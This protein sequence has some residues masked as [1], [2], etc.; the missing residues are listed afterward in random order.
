MKNSAETL[1]TLQ[2][3][4]GDPALNAAFEAI[5]GK[6]WRSVVADLEE[7]LKYLEMVLNIVPDVAN[8]M[9]EARKNLSSSMSRVGLGVSGRSKMSQFIEMQSKIEAFTFVFGT[10]FGKQSIMGDM[11]NYLNMSTKFG[12]AELDAELKTIDLNDLGTL[13][14]FVNANAQLLID[15]G[16]ISKESYINDIASGT[17]QGAERENLTNDINDNLIKTLNGYMAFMDFQSYFYREVVGKV[18]GNIMSMGLTG[19]VKKLGD[20]GVNILKFITET[21]FGQLFNPEK[22]AELAASGASLGSIIQSTSDNLFTDLEAALYGTVEAY[23]DTVFDIFKMPESPNRLLD[24]IDDIKDSPIMNDIKNTVAKQIII[25]TQ[26]AM[27]AAVGSRTTSMR[28]GGYDK[29]L[30]QYD[31]IKQLMIANNLD[32]GII[33]EMTPVEDSLEEFIKDSAEAMLSVETKLQSELLANLNVTLSKLIMKHIPKS[34]TLLNKA[35][36]IPLLGGALQMGIDILSKFISNYMFDY[37]SNITQTTLLNT[38]LSLMKINTG[39]TGEKIFTNKEIVELSK[40]ILLDGLT[41]VFDMLIISPLKMLL[42][43]LTFE[44]IIKGI[45]LE[46]VFKNTIEFINS[47]SAL[48]TKIVSTSVV[49]WVKN[50]EMLKPLADILTKYEA[51]DEQTEASATKLIEEQWG[52]IKQWVSDVTGIKMWLINILDIGIFRSGII[53]VFADLLKSQSNNDWVGMAENEKKILAQLG[54]SEGFY[55]AQQLSK[56]DMDKFK[57]MVASTGGG[58]GVGADV[59]SNLVESYALVNKALNEV[60]YS[61]IFDMK[62]LDDKRIKDELRS[63]LKTHVGE[64]MWDQLGL[65]AIISTLDIQSAV[66]DISGEFLKTVTLETGKKFSGVDIIAGVKSGLLSVKMPEALPT[67]KEVFASQIQELANSLTE[68]DIET[69]TKMQEENWK[70]TA[71]FF[72]PQALKDMGIAVD[73]AFI[74]EKGGWAPGAQKAVL[75][76][77]TEGKLEEI[78]G[79]YSEYIDI[80]LDSITNMG[81]T[82]GSMAESVEIIAEQ[83]NM[84]AD[85]LVK[86]LKSV[87]VVTDSLLG[88]FSGVQTAIA[89]QKM[90][91]ETEGINSIIGG[92]GAAGGWFQVIAGILG[93][94]AGLYQIWVDSQKITEQ[95]LIAIR[96]NT[97]ALESLTN[98]LDSLKATVYGAPAGFIYGYTSPVIKEPVTVQSIPSGNLVFGENSVVINVNGNADYD[99]VSRAV[100]AGIIM[101]S[102]RAR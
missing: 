52:S 27:E 88:M 9:R 71:M 25:D 18:E 92:I 33:G 17:F 79:I 64:N 63:G 41:F 48:N 94:L 37:V 2:L 43:E 59:A 81:A 91:Q 86:G 38:S 77:L 72:K 56:N 69:L 65:E 34:V 85:V 61:Y 55:V 35:L 83:W 30:E 58:G 89:G 24:L 76:T 19:I 6:D 21:I 60:L 36:D 11:M 97:V 66:K 49:D 1:T 50:I 75:A 7:P 29:D 67:S 57:H 12:I 23:K 93:G 82:F 102:K 32:L 47:I 10:L 42:G 70:S 95:Q 16:M 62:G 13:M 99:D 51:L 31:H 96:Q 15:I 53:K 78:E 4:L 46:S 84:D 90:A 45:S 44:D 54:G 87:G 39:L 101:A 100:E 26:E 28:A 20:I 68:A 14:E 74:N 3:Y 40:S 8:A 22:W 5:L 80:V 98:I 73:D